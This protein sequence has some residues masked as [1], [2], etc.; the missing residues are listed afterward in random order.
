VYQWESASPTVMENTAVQGV[1]PNPGA[2]PNQSFS[3]CLQ[4]I[5]TLKSNLYAYQVHSIDKK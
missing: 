5:K 1:R 4:I 2:T 3:H